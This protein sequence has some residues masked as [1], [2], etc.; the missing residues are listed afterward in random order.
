V[1]V[2]LGVT[3]QSSSAA[4]ADLAQQLVNAVNSSPDLQGA[5]GCAAGDYAVGWFGGAQFNLRAR[6]PGYAA[7]AIQASLSGSSGLVLAPSIPMPLTQ[8]LSDLQPRNHL[9]VA[10]GATSL[11]FSFPLDT[12]KLPDG[13]HELTAVA[14]EGSH[15]RTQTRTTL[16]IQVQNS[17]LAASL[18]LLDLADGAA[19]QGA[20]HVLVAANTITISTLCLYSTGGLLGATTNQS[21]AT[22]TV[23]GAGLGA[24]LHPFY[25]IAQT[26][27]GGQFRT[28]TRW[29]RLVNS[30]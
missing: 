7:A 25:A 28:Q 17:P 26:P 10:A 11:G 27:A 14:Y 4:A 20:Y 29:V 24:G 21:V 18:T 8:N 22:F 2:S 13:F 30:P 9:R 23:N 5:D 3:N 12:T 16:P 6:S 15:V 1:T 19:V